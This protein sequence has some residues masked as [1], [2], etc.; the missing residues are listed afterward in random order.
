[1]LCLERL[2]QMIPGVPP[3]PVFCDSMVPMWQLSHFTQIQLHPAQ[4]RNIGMTTLRV[5]LK[6]LL[7]NETQEG[8][9]N[10]AEGQALTP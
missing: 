5:L 1:M 8:D 9:N 4:L 6:R 10:L 7:A 2:E 3:N